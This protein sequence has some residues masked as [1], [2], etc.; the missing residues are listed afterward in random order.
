MDFFGFTAD[1]ARRSFPTAFQRVITRV[2][3][4]RDLNPRKSR[5]VNWWLFG[6]TNPKFRS[7]ASGLTRYAATSMT[8]KHRTFTFLTVDSIPDQGLIA[9]P[10]EDAFFL[11]VLSSHIH[12]VFT[13]A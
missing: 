5:R 9:F 10:L 6:E 7:A 4:E 13:L 3:P 12:I 11:G 1:D 2:K 8:A